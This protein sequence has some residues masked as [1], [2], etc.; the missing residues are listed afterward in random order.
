MMK[1]TWLLILSLTFILMLTSMGYLTVS[2]DSKIEEK[3]ISHYDFEEIDNDTIVDQK[4][5]RHGINYGGKLVDGISGQALELSGE[6]QFVELDGE[7]DLDGNWTIGYWVKHTN[8]NAERVSV[9][10]SHDKKRSFDIKLNENGQAGV[11]VGENSGDILT[12]GGDIPLN[13]WVHISWVQ[14]DDT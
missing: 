5:K 1:K 3:L 2:A 9:L 7:L 11:H 14:N 6:D 4:D 13:E 12:Y 10:M 8:S